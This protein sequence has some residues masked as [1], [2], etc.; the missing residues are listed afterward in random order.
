MGTNVLLPVCV[1]VCVCLWSCVCVCFVVVCVDVC[2]T[3]RQRGKIQLQ[4]RAE[5]VQNAAKSVRCKLLGLHRTWYTHM[6]TVLHSNSGAFLSLS[7][8]ISGERKVAVNVPE[9][10]Y[11]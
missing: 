5:V 6:Y 8:I 3:D 4:K 11:R 10:G 1:C 7:L 9:V 2:I